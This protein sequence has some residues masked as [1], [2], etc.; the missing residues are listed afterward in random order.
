MLNEG[1]GRS[2]E[3]IKGSFPNWESNSGEIEPSRELQKGY[4]LAKQ[5]YLIRLV[6]DG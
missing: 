1:E 5:S 4:S 6:K 2:G 3:E